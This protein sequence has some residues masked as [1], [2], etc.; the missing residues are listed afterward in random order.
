MLSSFLFSS[1]QLLFLYNRKLTACNSTRSLYNWQNQ[2]KQ[3]RNLNKTT[4]IRNKTYKGTENVNKGNKIGNKKSRRRRLFRKFLFHAKLRGKN[5]RNMNLN[6]HHADNDVSNNGETDNMYPNESNFEF[7]NSN[8]NN[9]NNYTD[10]TISKRQKLY[11]L[12][13]TTKDIYIPQIAS[14]IQQKTVE[15]FK[16]SKTTVLDYTTRQQ[17]LYQQNQNLL[18]AGLKINFIPSY[19]T[20]KFNNNYETRLRV[21]TTTP[22]NLS[23]R[24]NRLLY[25]LSRQYLK[26]TNDI[27]SSTNSSTELNRSVNTNSTSSSFS[28][29]TADSE[30]ANIDRF[31]S[32]LDDSVDSMDDDN[33]IIRSISTD[34]SEL[35]TLQTRLSGFFEKGVPS[36]PLKIEFYSNNDNNVLECLHEVTDPKGNLDIRV[37]TKNLPDWVKISID[38][39]LID[40]PT[41]N[42]IKKFSLPYVN[43]KGVSVISDIDDT[44]KHTGIT[45]NKKSMFRNVF[46]HDTSSWI[47]DGIPQWYNLLSNCYESDFFYVSNSPTQLYNVLKGY[48]F[49][50][51]PRGPLFLKQ[52]SGNIFSGLMASSANKKVGNIATIFNDFPEKKFILVG[53]SGEQ[54]FEAYIDTALN[55]PDQV[56]GIYIRCCKNSMSDN[57]QDDISVMDSLNELIKKEY[58]EPVSINGENMTNKRI[59]PKVP[60]KKIQLTEGQLASI[61]NSRS[62]EISHNEEIKKTSSLTDIKKTPSNSSVPNLPRR[63]PPPVLIPPRKANTDVYSDVKFRNERLQRFKSSNDNLD[64]KNGSG[65]YYMPSTQND[66]NTYDSN[67]DRKADNWRKRVSLGLRQLSGIQEH[68]I[69]LMFFTEPRFPQD[70]SIRLIEN[71]GCK[72]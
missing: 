41:P 56:L 9:N 19:T 60:S 53:D 47:I 2:R 33:A 57:P 35:A 59:P 5:K 36:I 68:N 58:I 32:T 3:I 65:D 54:D 24:K 12:M 64:H 50:N 15:G 43:A 30:N 17:Q 37:K 44:I 71:E 45:G 34:K 70:D 40:V 18:P 16:S 55:Y 23:S 69:S 10:D 46:V 61:Q 7:D 49:N 48:I 42:I 63:I 39:S 25:M 26:P 11:N 38:D 13:K 20:R 4:N 67:F 29:D 1:R 52:Y 22:G 14:T 31:D 21:F 51:L 6:N 62:I 28:A 27:V 66:Y 8:N 72:T